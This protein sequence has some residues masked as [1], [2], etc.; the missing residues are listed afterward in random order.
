METGGKEGELISIHK[1]IK[2]HHHRHHHNNSNKNKKKNKKNMSMKKK[3]KKKKEKQKKTK[4]IM[5]MDDYNFNRT[6][7]SLLKS[8][9][10]KDGLSN[11]VTLQN[12]YNHQ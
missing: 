10:F 11:H 7:R 9:K 8:I 12:S 4:K 5:M 1:C 2:F 3:K 6:E